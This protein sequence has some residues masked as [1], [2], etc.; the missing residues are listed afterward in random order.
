MNISDKIVIKNKI[1]KNRIV[2]PAMICNN[3]GD[4]DGFQTVDRSEHYAQRAK[5]GT[6]LIVVE[7]SAV[8]KDSKIEQ[9]AIGIWKDEHINQYRQIAESCHKYGTTVLVQIAHSGYKSCNNLTIKEIKS[10]KQDFVDAAIRADKAGMDGVEIHGAHGFLLNQFTSPT[11]NNRDDKYGQDIDSRFRLSIEILKEIVKYTSKD[12][13]ICYRLGINDITF[14]EDRILAKMLE[15]AGA[16]ILSISFGIGVDDFA[17][18]ESYP[19]SGITYMGTAIKSSVSIPVISVNNILIPSE[20]KWLINN[21]YTD[22][23]AVGRGLLADPDWANK[24]LYGG[25]VEKCFHC[26]SWCKYGNNGHKCP[27]YILRNRC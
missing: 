23:V 10:I 11:V 20:A 17:P 16:D 12:F 22:F 19:L 15:N 13:V 5:G 2:M 24:A 9:T 27:R 1:I 8:S 21:N 26:K 14:A 4:R 3:W 25:E 18:P 7:A 6:G